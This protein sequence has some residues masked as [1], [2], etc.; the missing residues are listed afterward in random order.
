MHGCSDVLELC[1]WWP[2]AHTCGNLIPRILSFAFALF[3]SSINTNCSHLHVASIRWTPL[4]NHFVK[5]YICSPEVSQGQSSTYKC[6]F[7]RNSPGTRSSAHILT[8]RGNTFVQAVQHATFEATAQPTCRR[9]EDAWKMP[10]C[11]L[12]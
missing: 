4:T 1:Q 2:P 5:I 8:L 3:S 10:S 7:P 6:H 9:K 12:K 11:R